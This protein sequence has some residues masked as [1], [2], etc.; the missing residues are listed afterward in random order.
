MTMKYILIVGSADKRCDSS[1][2]ARATEFAKAVTERAIT[3]GCGIAVLATHEPVRVEDGI[4][5]PL[6]FDWEVLRTVDR[7]LEN[8]YDTAGS[9][10]VRVFTGTDSMEK[11]FN[12]ENVRLFQHLQAK[13]ALDVRH[14]EEDLYSGGTYR[15]WQ[16]DLCDAMIAIGGGGGTYQVA[17]KM[18]SLGKPVM[19]LDIR[20]GSRHRDGEGAIQLLEEMKSDQQLFLPR[21]HQVVNSSLYAL[22]LE[23]PYW[24]VSKVADA[25][26]QILAYEMEETNG[27]GKKRKGTIKDFLLKAVGKTPQI[28]Q[29]SFHGSKTIET[30]EKLFSNNN[31]T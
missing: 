19:P 17:D 1:R 27:S 3:A 14:I 4:T 7:Y 21:S 29:S 10:I 25:V 26:V 11:R 22:S 12:A 18:L 28:A 9:G 30:I 23:Q 6:A 13:R 8:R 24:S 2:L 15:E 20:I 16:A 5:V 31:P